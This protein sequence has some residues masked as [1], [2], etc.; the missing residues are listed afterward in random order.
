[1]KMNPSKPWASM[2]M[3]LPKHLRDAL[4]KVCRIDRKS[5]VQEEFLQWAEKLTS[6]KR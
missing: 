4:K 2:Q 1:M 3:R 6:K 5:S